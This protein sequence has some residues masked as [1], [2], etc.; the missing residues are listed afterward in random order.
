MGRRRRRGGGLTN[1]VDRR[2][3]YGGIDVDQEIACRVVSWATED[4]VG[5]V[6]DAESVCA[7]FGGGDV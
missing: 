2:P 4:V 7:W 3:V 5:G 6:R 1:A